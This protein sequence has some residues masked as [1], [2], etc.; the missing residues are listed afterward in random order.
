MMFNWLSQQIYTVQIKTPITR[1]IVYVTMDK[2]K[3]TNVKNDID[4]A[5]EYGERV[6]GQ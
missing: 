3:A 5:I 4:A 2:E 6:P 1:Q